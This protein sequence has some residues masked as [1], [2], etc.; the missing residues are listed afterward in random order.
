MAIQA[1]QQDSTIT[2]QD[3]PAKAAAAVQETGLA[4]EK[5]NEIAEASQSDP[6]LMQRIQLAASKLQGPATP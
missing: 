4:P 3:K 6:E 1:V 2:E 5:F